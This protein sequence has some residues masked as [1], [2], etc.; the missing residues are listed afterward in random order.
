[1]K[2]MQHA[3]AGAATPTM[4]PVTSTDSIASMQSSESCEEASAH[5]RILDLCVEAD[6]ED[7]SVA[8]FV[9]VNPKQKLEA[10]FFGG[11]P[12]SNTF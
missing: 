12:R 8:S 11:I 7:W 4:T 3:K 10:S 6:M 5:A 1:M 2:R 9:P